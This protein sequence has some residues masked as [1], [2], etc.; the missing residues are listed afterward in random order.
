MDG[1]SANDV[2]RVLRRQPQVCLI[3]GLAYRNPPVS[4]HPERWQDVEELLAASISVVTSINLQYVKE[5]QAK[6]EAIRRSR[7]RPTQLCDG[8]RASPERPP[9]HRSRGPAT[10]ISRLPGAR[11]VKRPV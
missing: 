9:S 7:P 11:L 5:R 6:V 2:E 8:R 10:D 1:N 3:D 4:K